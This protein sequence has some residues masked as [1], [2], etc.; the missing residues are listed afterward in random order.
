MPRQ[1]KELENIPALG[2]HRP[3][4]SCDRSSHLEPPDLMR[5]FALQSPVFSSWG[6]AAPGYSLCLRRSLTLRLSELYCFCTTPRLWMNLNLSSLLFSL[7]VNHLIR[8]SLGLH[9]NQLKLTSF[10]YSQ[11]YIIFKQ[12]TH[13]F[14]LNQQKWTFTVLLFW[15]N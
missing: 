9:E 6:S 1:G 8:V 10:K 11:F 5:P 13:L 15:W 12:N 7:P 14:L 2:L 3:E 4:I